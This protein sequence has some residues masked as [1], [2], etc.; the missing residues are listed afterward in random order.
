MPVLVPVLVLVLVRG[1]WRG[2]GS[3]V[4]FGALREELVDERGELP[5]RGGALAEGVGV[6]P[7]VRAAHHFRAVGAAACGQ[8]KRVLEY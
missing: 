7:A 3:R 8:Y 5:A 4:G 1:C 2:C 6:A